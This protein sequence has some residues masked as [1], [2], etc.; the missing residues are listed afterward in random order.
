MAKAFRTWGRGS[1]EKAR[2]W[3]EKQSSA[4]RLASVARRVRRAKVHSA[5]RQWGAFVEAGKGGRRSLK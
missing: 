2:A 1:G 4:G 3:A 5:W